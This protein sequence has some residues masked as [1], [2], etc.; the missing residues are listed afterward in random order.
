VNRSNVLRLFVAAVCGGFAATEL[1]AQQVLPLPSHAELADGHHSASMPFGIPGFRTQILVAGS[2]IAPNGAVLTALRFRADRSSLPQ[3]GMS[4]PNV[5]VRL[6]HT[7]VALGNLSPTFAN[8]VTGPE[9]VVFQGT[10]LLP[11]HTTTL[12]QA[13]PLPWDIEVVLQSPFAYDRAQGN[14]LVEIVGANA[15]TQFP[16]FYLDACVAGGSANAFGRGGPMS[17]GDFQNL[18]LTT[19]GLFEPRLISPGLSIEFLVGTIHSPFPGV[20]L[21][22]TSTFGPGIDLGSIGAPGNKVY[23]D[24]IMLTTHAWQQGFIGWSTSTI[25]QVP[26]TAVMIG[27]RVYAQSLLLDAP[28][29][30]LGVVT[31]HALEVRI[32]DRVELFPMQQ[33]DGVGPTATTGSLMDLGL[34]LPEWGA[35]AMQLGGVFF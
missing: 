2:E 6:S 19:N 24:P 7:Q 25:I 33:L 29:N 16:L 27:E 31:S 1:R 30:P 17:S 18:L 9:T 20:L 26:S 11:D 10:V 15:P 35:V 32:G 12:P 8:N 34:L 22:G 21:L 4:V 14:L 23:V 5:T 3:A 13:G 28:A